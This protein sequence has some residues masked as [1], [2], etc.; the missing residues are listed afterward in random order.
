MK[1][2]A[3]M[4]GPLVRR[5]GWDR[6]PHLQGMRMTR[7]GAAVGIGSAGADGQPLKVFISYSRKDVDF[8]DDLELF[9]DTRGF[10]PI[11]DRHDIDHNDDW[12][13]RL[14]QLIFGCDVVV[15][16]LTNTSAASPICKW[17]VAEAARMGKRR[18]VVTPGP[19]ADGTEP[20]EGLGAANWIHC[21]RN[22]AVPGAS[23]A[24]GKRELETALRADVGWL[25]ERTRLMEQ[26]ASWSARGA[27]ADAPSLLRGDVLAEAQAW[28]RKTPADENVPNAVASF[29]SASETNEARLKAEAEAGL[30]EKEQ[31]LVAAANASRNVRRASLL[32]AGV[33]SIFLVAAIVAGAFALHLSDEAQIERGKATELLTLAEQRNLENIA[34]ESKRLSEHGYEETAI[35]MALY[36]DPA[37]T[38]VSV[39]S[40]VPPSEGHRFA[41]VRLAASVAD[42]QLAHV[43][44]TGSAPRSISLSSDSKRLISASEDGKARVWDL[45]TRQQLHE[46]GRAYSI[47]AASFSND[48]KKIA[49]ASGDIIETFDAHTFE[50]LQSL[51]IASEFGV[52]PIF[53]SA[54]D[55]R[56]FAGY[57]CYDLSTGKLVDT[58]SREL[59]LL[60]RKISRDRSVD[61]TF[62]GLA[63][64]SDPAG[65]VV[66]T[67][68]LLNAQ[69][70]EA[71]FSADGSAILTTSS[72]G[73]V[74]V[75]DPEF[76][77]QLQA[78]TG[79]RAS[80][81]MAQLSG[82]G[83][84]LVAAAAD[85]SI[86]VW[87]LKRGADM[88]FE[89]KHGSWTYTAS[90][91]PDGSRLIT[92]ANDGRA[93][94]WNA[95]T[96]SQMQEL[97]AAGA[98]R[99]ASFTPDGDGAATVSLDGRFKIWNTADGNLVRET[100]LLDFPKR[101]PVV[102]ISRAQDVVALGSGETA[103]VTLNDA[104]SGGVLQTLTG[105]A[106][107][108]GDCN[109]S[110]FSSYHCAG[111]RALSFSND[112][113]RLVS[114]SM[115]RTARIWD[116]KTGKTLHVLRGHEAP[117][118]S[119]T[120]SADGRRVVTTADDG[121]A[122][123]WDAASGVLL[124]NFEE[125]GRLV[126]A[127][128]F[129]NDGTKL[130]V[131]SDSIFN[132]KVRTVGSRPPSVSVW[133]VD[134]G[135]LL[136]VLAG[137]TESVVS[138][139]FSRDGR[140]MATT[141]SGGTVRVWNVPLIMLASPSDQ[142][143]IAC[144]ALW[145]ANAPLAFT[146]ADIVR[147]PVL[148]TVPIASA[149]SD[150]LSSPCDG[151][152]PKDTFP[153]TAPVADNASAP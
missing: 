104:K 120:F 82:N 135:D 115:D 144:E 38:R 12:R 16:V 4:E 109:R 11:L 54:D 23:I 112:G 25:R 57:E 18:L 52:N 1:L 98:V 124:R 137:H 27:A 102:A 49:L 130:A 24:K 101:L 7:A 40:G 114:T 73:I 67:L 151:V 43:F 117:V 133:D 128:A 65:R 92:G 136:F 26:A 56:V 78:F 149:N 41:R 142:V 134:S 37:A 85:G 15:F 150:M 64:V 53:F 5:L 51:E 87:A 147:F 89:A 39:G 72:D 110:T 74:R 22:P 94:T 68:A 91:S 6:L 71:S 113:A 62:E 31:A 2:Y 17:E 132:A 55:R 66:T 36:A 116:V 125:L 35:L 118:K 9:L 84:T 60:R 61:T 99:S 140:K 76:G 13:P 141:T 127:A 81:R 143:K 88:S 45:D 63:A 145:K 28:A 29:L 58:N 83:Q 105:H 47:D 93:R 42:L 21:W 59:Q 100:Q 96:G 95:E 86:Y 123:I 44:Q 14:E 79:Y 148:A 30:K 126:R 46:F 106:V 20:P 111:I 3:Q 75:W 119:A 131:S 80:L 138:V 50:S 139:D 33:A 8:A 34:I 97:F 107:T 129:S 70:I 146:K 77:T 153:V 152:L 19:L 48:G 121:T 108:E 32:G 122:R 10:D 103:S 69:I 90:F